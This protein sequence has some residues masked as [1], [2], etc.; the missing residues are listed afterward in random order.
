V[1]YDEL[2]AFAESVPRVPKRELWCHPLVAM[3]LRQE[4]PYR[5]HSPFGAWYELNSI[6]VFED[7]AM[8]VGAWEVREDGEVTQSGNIEWPEYRP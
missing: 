1:N 6:P 3:A 5:V 8:G 2:A 7:P 4:T